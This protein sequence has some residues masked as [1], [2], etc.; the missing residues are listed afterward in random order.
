MG[1]ALTLYEKLTKATDDETRA[2]LIAE[3]L[4][5]IEEKAANAENIATHADV[6]ESELRL[7]KEIKETEGRLKL[8]IEG[9][10][11]E[12]KEIEGRLEL[13]IKKVEVNLLKAINAQTRWFLG[14][15]AILGIL[16]KMMDV[17]IK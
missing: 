8:E 5:T 17:F 13:E 7:Q 15:L 3:A 6:R 1:V 14:G 2:K 10:R 11:K 4:E 16:F 12:I 9:I